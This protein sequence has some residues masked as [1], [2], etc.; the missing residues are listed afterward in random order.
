MVETYFRVQKDFRVYT[1]D[2]AVKFECK[3]VPFLLIRDLSVKNRI[4][5]YKIKLILK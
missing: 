4:T 2:I 1:F 5:L 3:I